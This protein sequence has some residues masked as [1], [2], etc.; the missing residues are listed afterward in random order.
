MSSS[1]HLFAAVAGYVGRPDATG[2]AGVFRRDSAPGGEWRHVMDACQAHFV[3]V[4][5]QAPEIVL[6]GTVDGV[7]RSSDGGATF[8][9]ARCPEPRSQVWCFAVDA[10]DP[11]RVWAGASPVGVLL[12]EDWGES[13]AALPDPGLPARLSAPFASRVLRLVQHPAEPETLW[14]AL[15]FGGAMVSRNGGEHWTDCGGALAALSKQPHLESRIVSDSTAEGMLDGHA[16][17]ISPVDPDSVVLALR[18][19]LFESRDG[20]LSWQDRKVGRFSPTTY[21]RDVRVAPSAPGTL[22]AALSVA[23]ASHDG[24]V[25]RS[26]NRG[27]TWQRFDKVQVHGTI[28]SIGLHREDPAQL[29]IGARYDGE[30]FGTRDGGESWDEVSIPGDV[31]DIYCVACG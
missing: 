8:E 30:I 17:A 19:G 2:A 27:E 16:I 13:W 1:T 14:A 21:G 15:E 3:L 11:R 6:A 25:Y 4:H 23:A 9:R 31:K 20:G 5:P 12:S 28:M 10:G 26:V 29:W 24:G 18:M 7:Y 22:Y